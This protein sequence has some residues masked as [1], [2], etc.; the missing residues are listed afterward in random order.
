[1]TDGPTYTS[2]T[3][4]P[5][6]PDRN[7]AVS[8][9]TPNILS[10]SHATGISVRPKTPATNITIPHIITGGSNNA[11]IMLAGR[12]ISGTILKYAALTTAVPTI[13]A[14]VTAG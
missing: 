9:I 7:S 3:T 11:P 5:D 13:A 12:N 2:L 10:V 4:A 8:V 14:N 6:S 1:M